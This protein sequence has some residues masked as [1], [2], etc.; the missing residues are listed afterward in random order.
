MPQFTQKSL[1]FAVTGFALSLSVAL[2]ATAGT[3]SYSG[4][5]TNAPTFHRPKAQ[6]FEGIE[7]PSK[8]LSDVGTA[9]SYFSQ[10]FSVD[11][12][13]S[14]D[15]T[16]TQAFDGVQFLYQNFFDPLSPITNLI[17]GK[18][19]FPDVGNSGFSGLSLMNNTPY[20]LVTAGYDN[21]NSPN[22]SYGKF[23]NTI[24][25]AGNIT[26]KTA[27]PVPEPS[28]AAGTIVFGL[29]VAGGQIRKRKLRLLPVAVSESK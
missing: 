2:P 26:L 6:G 11:T 12:A 9:V 14:Y 5:T 27:T 10:A 20:F 19:S 16:G 21:A 13:G 23:T 24:A 28:T 17:S 3:L 7:D 22:I 15:V 29:M 4:D 1:C 25:G 8:S 18:D